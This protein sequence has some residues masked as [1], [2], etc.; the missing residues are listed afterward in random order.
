MKI[1]DIESRREYEISP[2]RQTGEQSMVCPKCSHTRTKKSDKPMHWNAEKEAGYCH[3]CQTSFSVPRSIAKPEYK[4]PEWKN[5]TELS[6]GVVQWFEKRGISQFTLRQMK[7]TEGI[8]YMPQVG[9]EMNTVQF[10]YFREDELINVKYR[11]GDKKF[12]MFKDGELIFY[13]LDSIRDT[14]TAIITEGEIDALS[15]YE[16]GIHNVVSVPNGASTGTNNLQYLDNCTDYFEGKTSIILATDNDLPGVNLRNDLASRLGVERCYRVHFRE[17]KD[18]N[19]YLQKNGKE[20]LIKVIEEK[21]AFPVE[22]IF[23][24]RDLFDDLDLLYKEGLKKGFLVDDPQLDECLSFE[25]GRLYTITGIPGHGKSE[26]LDQWLALLNIK[27]GLKFGYFSPENYPLQLHQSKLISRLT[28]SKFGQMWMPYSEFIDAMNYVS[29][30]FYWVMPKDEFNLTT[31]LER[32]RYLVF[33]RG[34]SGFVIDPYNKLEHKMERGESETNYI[35]RF[36]DQLINF[37]HKTNVAVFLV[38]HPRKMQKE[39]DTEVKKMEVPNLYDIN[40]SANFYNKTD[41]GITIYRDFVDQKVDVYIQKVKFK[42]LGRVGRIS[43]SYSEANGRFEMYGTS[44]SNFDN[45]NWLKSPARTKV[46]TPELNFF[47]QKKVEVPF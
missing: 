8:E 1:I 14:D 3:H 9:K 26:F 6:D 38:A 29:E 25:R 37:S 40:G 33:R 18:A 23:T 22:G 36:L 21:E 17:C 31:I 41:F 5:N 7:V 34:I 30:N 45:N 15:F 2:T 24:A 13:N 27:H 47:D 39:R 32:A 11:T 44:E 4:R 10:N 42:H 12:K 43:Y 16:A 20:A 46:K 35:S 19:E 28:G